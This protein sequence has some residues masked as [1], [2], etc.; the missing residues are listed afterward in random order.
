MFIVVSVGC[1]FYTGE[2]GF[3]YL[4]T[5]ERGFEYLEAGRQVKVDSNET[6][7]GGF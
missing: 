1:G 3:E 5:D 4:E 2:G 6:D 7:E